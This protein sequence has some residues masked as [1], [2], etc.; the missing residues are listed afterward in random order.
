MTK[1]FDR[2]C[3][4]DATVT[5][6]LKN[7]IQDVTTSLYKDDKLFSI[8]YKHDSLIVF[9]SVKLTS[10]ILFYF[11]YLYFKPCLLRL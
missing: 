2:H 11:N 5:G 10:Y 6:K 9:I 3:S 7:I 4:A 1:S 8:K